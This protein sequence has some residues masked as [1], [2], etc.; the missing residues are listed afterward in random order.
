MRARVR[1]DARWYN[2][3]TTPG[4]DVAE[5]AIYDEIGYWGLSADQFLAELREITASEIHLRLN[6]P[7]GEIF[8][9]VA[10]HNVLR[11][12]SARVTVFVDSLA[13]SIASVIAMA[14][15]KVIMQPHS[16][17]MI[18]DGSGLCIGDAAEMRRMA[19][20]LDR[21]SDNIAAVYAERAGGTARQWRAR[22]VAETWYTAQE[23]VEAGLA[24]EVGSPP[25]RTD[26]NLMGGSWDL[27][28]FR[29]AGREAAPA[30]TAVLDE[31]TVEPPTVEPEKPAEPEQPVEPVED[32]VA[33]LD[34]TGWDPGLFRTAMEAATEDAFEANYDPDVLRAAIR[35][36]ANN[37]PAPPAIEPA[38]EPELDP[39]DPTVVVAAIKEA[40][41]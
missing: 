9:G 5:V 25:R 24:D 37:A 18:H 28:V 21:Q 1:P 36:R 35:E 11:S 15:D 23:A 16:Q 33:E 22:M 20:D 17:M 13:A 27:T 40:F 10:I 12:H 14:G 38:S 7:G 41:R 19:D 34:L 3:T 2:I 32:P 6:S 8:D 4:S 26:E 39:Y 31:P 30:P 29:H